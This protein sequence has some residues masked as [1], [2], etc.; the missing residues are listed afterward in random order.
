MQDVAKALRIAGIAVG[1]MF[2]GWLLWIVLLGPSILLLLRP[3]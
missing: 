1:V 3:R 2:A